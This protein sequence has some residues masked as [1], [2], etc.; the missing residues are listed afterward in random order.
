MGNSLATG[1]NLAPT[2]IQ[3]LKI[4][5]SREEL[6]IPVDSGI[7]LLLGRIRDQKGAEHS[8]VCRT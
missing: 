7:V 4:I 2:Q 3:S 1:Y 5:S 8:R 6:R